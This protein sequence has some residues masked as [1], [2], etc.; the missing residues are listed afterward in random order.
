MGASAGSPSSGCS[1]SGG[2]SFGGVSS[3]GGSSGSSS[4]G[5]SS[6]LPS[7]T[8]AS[9]VSLLSSVIRALQPQPSARA[10]TEKMHIMVMIENIIDDLF[11]FLICLQVI[12]RKVFCY[13][14]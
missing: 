8:S 14:N 7:A 4:S 10:A 5:S 9:S 12:L 3:S 6:F 11:L 1:S 13:P 2:S